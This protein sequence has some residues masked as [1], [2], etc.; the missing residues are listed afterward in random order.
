MRTLAGIPGLEVR[1]DAPLAPYTSMRVG[2]P[3]DLLLLPSS[4]Q[5]L[6]SAWRTLREGRVP[7]L[8]L[9]N[10]TNL[11]VRDGGVRGAVFHLAQLPETFVREDD[12]VSASAQWLLLRLVSEGHRHGY[13]GLE[14]AAGIPGS[15]GGALTMNAG[16]HGHEFQEHVLSVTVVDDAGELRTWPRA[17]LDFGYRRSRLQQGDVVAVAAR[18]QL[19]HGD[20]QEGRRRLRAFL[21]ERRRTQP[22]GHNA[23]SMFKNPPGDYAGRLIEAVGGKGRRLGGAEISP[24]HANFIVNHGGARASDVLGLVAWAQ[25]EVERRF[26]IRLELEVQVIGEEKAP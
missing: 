16:C 11:L 15:L 7:T 4:L 20:V 9:G 22:M 18:L 12:G 14:W 10:G 25:D 19:D 17:E 3:A 24:K 21:D 1:R 8:V 2:G 5:A 13:T 26:G 23:G 6:A